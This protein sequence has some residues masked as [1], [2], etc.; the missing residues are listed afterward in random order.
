[1]TLAWLRA[2]R[3]AGSLLRAF[4]AV[5]WAY[6]WM[7]PIAIGLR[8]RPS[9]AAVVMGATLAAFLARNVV[10]P[11]RSRPR[12]AARFRLRPCARYLP[13][14]TLAV[15]AKVT[16]MLS[17]VVLH[18]EMAS[19]RLLPPLPDDP[20]IVSPT[21]VTHPLGAVALLLAVAALAPLIEEFAFRG[22]MQRELERSVGLGAAILIPAIGFSLLHGR[23]DAVH[24]VPYAILAG[25]TVWRTGSIW[26]AV[27]M[28]TLNNLIAGLGFYLPNPS[29]L[30]ED[31]PS[32][33][34]PVALAAGA[35]ALGGL[36]LVGAGV[37]RIASRERPRASAWPRARARGETITAMA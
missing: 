33:L 21:F 4:L 17:G 6:A 32:G 34:W 35:I 9:I 11:L 7:I 26:T 20:E 22:T 16:L 3:L 31:I 13:L 37:H 28:H 15:V 29:W 14:L 12:L 25:W 24:H 30:A 2:R 27:Y 19:R 8:S 36:G 23:V 10:R 5:P 18:E 1:M